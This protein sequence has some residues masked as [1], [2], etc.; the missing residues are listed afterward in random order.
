MSGETMQKLDVQSK[1]QVPAVN[2]TQKEQKEDFERIVNHYLESNPLTRS[3]NKTN[4]LEVRFGTNPKVAKPL[5]KID[6]DNVVKQLYMCGFTPENDEGINM[7]RIQNE[8]TDMKTGLRKMS[9]VRAEIIGL[10][11]IQEYCRTNS[12]QKII[13]MPS[14]TFN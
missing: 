4:E 3:D 5:N 10:D 13:D 1:S 12:L 11:L 6:Y 14:T 2:K 9:N 7:L 8:F